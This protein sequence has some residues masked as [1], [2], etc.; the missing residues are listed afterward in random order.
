MCVLESSRYVALLGLLFTLLGCG[1][2]NPDASLT[3]VGAMLERSPTAEAN[4]DAEP[5]VET[6]VWEPR[7]WGFPPPRERHALAYD[8]ARGKVVLFGG[9]SN[10]GHGLGDTWEWD[11]TNWEEVTPATSP[12][13]RVSHGLAYDSTRE[14]VVLFGGEGWSDRHLGDTWEWDGSD[15]ILRTP[16]TSPPRS[17]HSRPCVRQRAQQGR[18]LR[19]RDRKSVV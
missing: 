9:M 6:A 18:R 4:L 11:G 14:R 19:R 16:D 7:D 17:R 12:Q 13:A 10:E 5:P 1:Q 8:S 3:A 2:T 15:W